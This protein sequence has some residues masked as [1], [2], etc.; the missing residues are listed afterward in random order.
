MTTS[1]VLVS[2]GTIQLVISGAPSRWTGYPLPRMGP[3]W[4]TSSQI[5]AGFEDFSS[6]LVSGTPIQKAVHPLFIITSHHISKLASDLEKGKTS[7]FKYEKW[8]CDVIEGNTMRQIKERLQLRFW[9]SVWEISFS[10]THKKKSS[11]QLF[12]NALIFRCQNINCQGGNAL[13]IVVNSHFVLPRTEYNV[14]S[15]DYFLWT[16]VGLL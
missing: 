6:S 13:E 11:C 2:E 14:L 1:F 3:S 8:C 15:T 7:P 12:L 10:P 4:L 9:T 16:R 5:P